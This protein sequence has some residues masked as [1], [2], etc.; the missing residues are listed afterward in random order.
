MTL[1]WRNTRG[2]KKSAVLPDGRVVRYFRCPVPD[3]VHGWRVD[4]FA[5]VEGDAIMQWPEETSGLVIRAKLQAWAEA[6]FPLYALAALGE[7]KRQ[8]RGM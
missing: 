1:T 8:A 2:G 4:W 7:N 6:E 3:R 5:T